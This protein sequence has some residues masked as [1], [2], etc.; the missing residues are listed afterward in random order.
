MGNPDYAELNRQLLQNPL[1][2]L[3]QWFPEGKVE[4]YNFICLNP[5]YADTH[6]SLTIKLNEGNWKD[7]GNGDGGGDLISLYAYIHK[8]HNSEAFKQ[9]SRQLGVNIN[10]KPL[11]SSLEICYPIPST[12]PDDIIRPF[13]S[14]SFKSG[15]LTKPAPNAESTYIKPNARHHYKDPDGQT[16][17]YIYRFD[18][19]NFKDDRKMFIPLTLWFDKD[20]K[21]YRWYKKGLPHNIKKPLYNLQLLKQY[22]EKPVLILAGELKTDKAWSFIMKHYKYDIPF[23]PMSIMG[24]DNAVDKVDFSPILDREIIWW[25]D[26]DDCKN[27]FQNL[28][29]T[30]HG[31]V[32]N[33]NENTHPRGWDCGDAIDEGI[34]IAKFVLD[35]KAPIPI[36]I[37]ETAPIDIFPHKTKNKLKVSMTNIKALLKHYN[38]DIRYNIIKLNFQV[39]ISGVQYSSG[40]HVNEFFNYVEHLCGINDV[41][42]TKLIGFLQ[43]IAKERAFN[44]FSEWVFSKKWDGINRLKQIQDAIVAKD[45]FD[46]AFKDILMQ[47]WLTAVVAMGCRVDE[48]SNRPRCALVFQGRQGIGKTTFFRN[49]LGKHKR[50]FGEGKT[51]NLDN[52][53]SIYQALKY[54]IVEL[55]ELES[56]TKRQMP[57]LKA[58]LTNDCTDN[59]RKYD[60][61]HEEIERRTTFCGT[62]NGNEFLTDGTD[63]SRFL[64][65]P[66]AYIK[67]IQHIDMQQLWAE[68]YENYYLKR[69]QYWLTDDED[70]QLR[71]TNLNH[72]VTNEVDDL[73]RYNL[74]WQLDRDYYDYKNITEILEGLGVKDLGPAN[75]QRAT[76]ILHEI[77]GD[78]DNAYKVER[79]TQLYFVPPFKIRYNAQGG[80]R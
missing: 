66:V 35:N 28:A 59:R 17:L 16:L 74:E 54:V 65:I 2:Y 49:L 80:L 56:T 4:G 5:T 23:I 71:E 47:R 43:T 1:I 44:P 22:P 55:G 11:D 64:V 41:P 29:N 42:A 51:L 26:N 32:L 69:Q 19:E 60:R 13:N 46:P 75:R 24:G 9:L 77:L 6:S 45:S 52:E 27:V 39:T 34:D 72:L 70:E 53:D 67:D 50:L 79:K 3:Q 48:D 61:E 36:T 14:M 40:K 30:Y 58:F 20:E 7:F 37:D 18:K 12:L 21:C 33:I 10:E 38:F 57:Q 73:I 63:N 62:V 8:I 78:D 15:L 31:R 68:M 25:A 76:R